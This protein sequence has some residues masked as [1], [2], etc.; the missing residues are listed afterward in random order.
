MKMTPS[1]I[2]FGSLILFVAVFFVAVFL[3]G[4]TIGDRPSDI[5]RTRSDLEKEGRK[6]YVS[7]RMFVLPFPIRPEHRLG[8]GSG[9]DRP[10][11]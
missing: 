4:L 6:L 7:K 8:A 10:V 9:T 1:L 3:P 2:I 5:Y 11:R